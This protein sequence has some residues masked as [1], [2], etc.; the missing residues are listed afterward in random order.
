MEI[1]FALLIFLGLI[2]LIGHGIWVLLAAIGRAISG[3][4][5]KQPAE[6][7]LNDK[8]STPPRTPRFCN[9]CGATLGANANLCF[10]CGKTQ[11]LA[12]A[13]TL[14]DL[15]AT[16]RQLKRF[17]EQGVLDDPKFNWLS[18]IITTERQRLTQPPPPI[19]EKPIVILPEPVPEP[20][21]PLRIESPPTPSL[22][23]PVEPL[24]TEAKPYEAPFIP[25]R[26]IAEPIAP[27]VVEPPPPRKSFAEM[28]A[29]FMEEKNIRWGELLG[30][31]LIIGCSL[32]L[33][34][35]L[36]AQI[37]QIPL[38]KF[39][40]FTAMTGA[41]AG[42]GFYSEH[43][44]KLP[45]TSR[46]L[47]ITATMLV[48][49]NFLAIA[50]FAKDIA[51]S[52]PM[53]IASEAISLALFLLMVYR[54]GKV[55]TPDWA[56]WLTIGTVGT[57]ATQLILRRV[58]GLETSTI[59][60][61]IGAALPIAC[62]ATA[63]FG[64]L[65]TLRSAE[66]IEAKRINQSFTL[67]SASSF[68][69]LVTLGLLLFKTQ[70]FVGT[71]QRIAPMISLLAIP[72]LFAGILL[73]QHSKTIEPQ[74]LNLISAS[75]GV[76]SAFVMLASLVFAW[77]NP[78]NVMIVAVIN[79]VAL[80]SIAFAFRLSVAHLIALP[81][82]VLAYLL[83]VNLILGRVGATADSQAL[84]TALSSITSGTALAIFFVPLLLAS[85][86]LY[87]RE[88]KSDGF[89]YAII[90]AAV[91][92][93]SLLVVSL[94][95]FGR[96]GDPHHIAWIYA[97][98]AASAFYL[99]GRTKR[100]TASYVGLGLTFLM[101]V[102]F[103]YFGLSRSFKLTALLF[104]SLALI[105]AVAL[106]R[107]KTQRLF[108]EPSQ[109]VALIAAILA[110]A[111]LLL[112]SP[113]NT[114]LILCGQ[115]LW[116][117]GLV[118]AL[119]WLY[120]SPVLFTA[121]QAITYA[122]VFLAVTA[123]SHGTNLLIDLPIGLRS[124]RTQMLALAL[125]SPIWIVLRLMLR[126]F[127]ITRE[128]AIA[129]D[130]PE[131]WENT[132]SR[133]LYPEWPTCD[134]V[135]TW[136]LVAC[137]VALSL[138]GAV[139]GIIAEIAPALNGTVKAVHVSILAEWALLGALLFVLTVSLWEQFTKWRVLGLLL[140]LAMICPLI[141]QTSVAT[142][143]TLR[144]TAAVYLLVVSSA[145]WFREPLY[146]W[147]Q[148]LRFPLLQT[149]SQRLAGYA[150][151]LTM[152]LA[153]TPII[154]LTLWAADLQIGNGGFRVPAESF[155][156]RLGGIVSYLVPLVVLSLVLV[157]HAIRE[158]SSGYALAGGIVLNFSASLAFLNTLSAMNEAAWVRL[159]Q[160]NAITSAVFALCWLGAIVWHRKHASAYN[161][162]ADWVLRFQVMIGAALSF[163][164]IGIAGAVIF[165]N[166]AFPGAGRIAVGSGWGWLALILPGACVAAF[167]R[168]Q[169]VKLSLANAAI[170]LLAVGVMLACTLSRWDLGT[171][172]GY[173]TMLVAALTITALLLLAGFRAQSALQGESFV[174]P[175]ASREAIALTN[176][177]GA[178][179]LAFGARTLAGDPNN[180]WWAVATFVALSLLATGLARLALSRNYFYIAGFL[181]NAAVSVW[182][183]YTRFSFSPTYWL[184]FVAANVIVLSLVGIALFFFERKTMPEVK[185]SLPP[186]H[187]FASI[188]SL[189]GVAGP[190]FIGLARDFT[191]ETATAN[192]RLG[193]AAL[194]TTVALMVISLWDATAKYAVGGLYL[195][196]LVIAGMTLGQFNLAP[197][198]LA[199]A[200]TITVAVYIAFTSWLWAEK[201]W[202]IDLTAT[203]GIPRREASASNWLVNANTLL[204]LAVVWVSG[205]MVLHFDLLNQRVF[206]AVAV[207]L[208]TLS[209][210]LLAR[211]ATNK[212]WLQTATFGIGFISAVFFGWAFLQPGTETNLISHL[213]LVLLASVAFVELLGLWG[214]K[215]F[216][217][218]WSL[219]ARRLLRPLSAIA[220]L[221]LISIFAVEITEQLFAG[222]VTMPMFAIL[223]VAVILFGLSMQAIYFAV[224][225]E[226]DPL[227]LSERGRMNY[228]YASEALLGLTFL[229]IRLTMPWLFSGF[230]TRYW[231]FVVM[232]LAFAGVGLGELF[233]R[234]GQ[235]VLG[236]PL[237]NTGFFLP[238]FP[239]VGFW[240]AASKVDY[241]GLLLL[242]G[243]LYAVVAILRSSFGVSLMACLAANGSL[244]YYLS[245][246]DNFSLLERPQL[247]L[248]PAAIS[249]LIAAYL[250]RERLTATQMTNL[251]YITLSV[252][253]VSS[254]A[255]IFI[256]G[257]ALSPWQPMVL[258]LLSAAGVLAGILL[259]VRAFL[260]LGS[261]FLMISILSMIWHA[262][263]NFGWTWLWYVTGIIAGLAIILLF[264]MFEKKRAELL[265]LVEGLRSWEA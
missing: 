13:E 171:W 203:F 232:V 167:K 108:A 36:W 174:A 209:F 101:L 150:R 190:V 231:P 131:A 187:H 238:I 19:P 55:V 153:A 252:I 118:A 226:S 44:W 21:R 236:E 57:S 6:L 66:N 43:R 88:R 58:V 234:R 49:L 130:L 71:L 54:A 80:T 216:T 124:L 29:A 208:Q 110:G 229:H 254:T 217:P 156:S 185:S 106:R 207:A 91:A 24:T 100:T 96:T 160:I 138:F 170:G 117:A 256:R 99:A 38:L 168:L 14:N 122:S 126:K 143:T 200:A 95:G 212:S 51:A 221:A 56:Q 22:P 50:A 30:G 63:V 28:L 251:R 205:W 180:P 93:L 103:L 98:F 125:L 135:V 107:E 4:D 86:M 164:M 105:A 62:Y 112:T 121:F 26:P 17:H 213:T 7:R 67:L 109:R 18:H 202:L 5:T 215:R 84:F 123:S 262:S 166:P 147:A 218:E 134:Q 189:L 15:D 128:A 224:R 244:W 192:S 144:W 214:L 165:M 253:Y 242:V 239:V 222:H 162:A 201:Q 149:E 186:Y 197:R 240:L 90:T 211:D 158:H 257:V 245:R 182:H 142:A 64:M 85:E 20:V 46:G 76:F 136:A 223:I 2:T 230:F 179:A 199:F 119:S 37:E 120:R 35:S 173:H 89:F 9:D 195:L 97:L 176:I 115:T 11:N 47:L 65:K 225:S 146:V 148:T 241:S 59:G 73:W 247:W 25:P 12:E 61:C 75:V 137:F 1:L 72:A 204:I 52:N 16:E 250:N 111:V 60:L 114:A 177:F 81:S 10:S 227:Q 139:S 263:A 27:R 246:L 196:G 68:A 132:A 78:M 34:I 77:P 92:A 188:V 163:L 172:L 141:A 87:R 53:V 133:L 194:A 169:N 39:F 152:L 151:V 104:A 70:A 41:F 259:R 140:L 220:V 175:T 264:A 193:W 129:Q 113:I 102:Q 145:I 33:V 181:A 159:A 248:T 206:A 45:N 228:V 154:G 40:I 155:F 258:M 42:L 184:E 79:F 249:V 116:L 198:S 69:A 255:E 8:P 23:R 31:M 32:A 233:R 82:L 210:A 237:L 74:Y 265:R 261:S 83:G 157:G 161:S 3:N 191:L 94:H 178:L 219:A 235:R 183:S 260:Y 48:P 127:G 243:M